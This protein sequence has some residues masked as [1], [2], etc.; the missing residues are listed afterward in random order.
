MNLRTPMVLSATLAALLAPRA[1]RAHCDTLDGPVVTTARAALESGKIEAVL[2]WVQPAD[3]EE[4]RR[5][6]RSARAVRAGGNE[7]RALADRWFLETVVRVHRAGEGAPYT[8][9]KPAGAPDP[10]VAAVD[11]VIAGGDPEVLDRLLVESVRKGLHA[12][13]ARIREE[14]PPAGDVAAGRRWVAAYVPF[15]HWAEGVRAAATIAG[16]H[17]EHGADR[18]RAEPDAR[19]DPADA[20]AGHLHGG[21][22]AR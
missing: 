3:E 5:A 13:L 6:F 22:A 8:G 10:A 7:A 14:R 21:G 12:H 18:H 2:A 4:I 9:L 11:R 16:D 20:G 15:V 1:A 19:P 17:A